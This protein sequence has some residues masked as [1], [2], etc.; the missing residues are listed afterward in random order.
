MRETE[1]HSINWWEQDAVTDVQINVQNFKETQDICIAS[2]CLSQILITIVVL[3]YVYKFYNTSP[4]RKH[5]LIPFS[6]SVHWTVWPTFK[7]Q[8]T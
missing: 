2:K 7:E 3:A 4:S 8:S 5:S 6:L 1:H